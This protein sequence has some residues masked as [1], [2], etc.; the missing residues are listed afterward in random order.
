[1]I[2]QQE[3]LP[4]ECEKSQLGP[5]CRRTRKQ[6]RVLKVEWTES[7]TDVAI[8]LRRRVPVIIGLCVDAPDIDLTSDSDSDADRGKGDYHRLGHGPDSDSDWL[9]GGRATTT[10]WA[11]DLTLTLTLTLTGGRATTTVWATDLTRTLTLTLT[12]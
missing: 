7:W 5:S 12:G 2:R 8:N 10:V 6:S 4:S 1:M 3:G 11:T 9:T